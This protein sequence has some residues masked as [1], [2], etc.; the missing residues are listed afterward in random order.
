MD[1]KALDNIAFPNNYVRC[2][3]PNSKLTLDNLQQHLLNSKDDRKIKNISSQ[4]RQAT[5]QNDDG[6]EDTVIFQVCFDDQTGASFEIKLTVIQGEGDDDDPD[7]PNSG[8]GFGLQ[9]PK[10]LMRTNDPE[11]AD[12]I[13]SA[14]ASTFVDLSTSLGGGKHY[15][16]S[17]T[18]RHKWSNLLDQKMYEA[19]MNRADEFQKMG[20]EVYIDGVKVIDKNHT[21]D[22]RTG[23]KNLPQSISDDKALETA[24]QQGSQS[25]T[26]SPKIKLQ[27]DD[28]QLSRLLERARDMNLE[29]EKYLRNQGFNP[30]LPDN[31]K[32]LSKLAEQDNEMALEVLKSVA[33]NQEKASPLA[34]RMLQQVKST[35]KDS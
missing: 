28:C 11:K 7:N 20:S 21:Y 8:R 34:Q 24:L 30:E 6:G 33:E 17:P 35:K 3:S 23:E 31:I 18:M 14:F 16:N 26:F 5:E 22:F 15:V 27:K 19:F 1:D 10:E 2:T 25:L 12:K 29:P 32:T 4:I 9:E 13:A